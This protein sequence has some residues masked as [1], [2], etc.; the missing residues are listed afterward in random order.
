MRTRRNTLQWLLPPGL[1]LA[2]GAALWARRTLTLGGVVR[3]LTTAKEAL[4]EHLRLTTTA[5]ELL[6]SEL[7]AA[8]EIQLGLLP[9]ILPQCP[10]RS[11]FQLHGMIKSARE[12]GGDLYDFFWI[13]EHRF[14]FMIGDVSEKGSPAGMLM[15]VTKTLM[16]SHVL[17]HVSLCEAL[18]RVND[19]LAANNESL[20][21]VTVFCGIL[22]VRTG[23]LECCDGGHNEPCLLL[24][25]APATMLKK[26]T[27]IALGFLPGFQF[28]SQMIT[29]KP[30]DGLLLYTDGIT[31]AMNTARDQYTEARLRATLTAMIGAAPRDLVQAVWNDVKGF[32]AEAPQS[33]DIAMLAVRYQGRPT[34]EV[35][36]A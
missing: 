35:V 9:K 26:K 32:I 25:E 30:G 18:A 17:P 2:A 27:G 33:D 6:E 14:F 19:T 23:E 8:S 15:A 29:L 31:E 24:C 16:K 12:I 13:D 28:Q 21:F 7:R 20:M 3:E 36:D 1:L 10:N 22:D 4:T 34:V 5:K 11:E